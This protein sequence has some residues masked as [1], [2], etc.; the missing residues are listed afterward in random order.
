MGGRGRL[1]KYG[2]VKKKERLRK[3]R[4]VQAA[5]ERTGL[6]RTREH[7]PFPKHE[8]QKDRTRIL[9][10]GDHH[11]GF[12]CRLSRD[13]FRE[14]GR[15]SGVFVAQLWLG[16]DHIHVY[17]E[18]DVDRSV[19]NLVLGIKRFSGDAF[20]ARFPDMKDRFS[21]EGEVWDPAY[22]VGTVG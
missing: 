13:V 5:F 19:E 22:F 7:A 11:A 16:A 18:C 21:P 14:Y 10:A 3:A 9:R 1:G 8:A 2:E 4:S 20:L 6:P 17:A 12:V 15:S